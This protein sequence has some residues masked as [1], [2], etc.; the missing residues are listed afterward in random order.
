M[1]ESLPL[2]AVMFGFA[3][4]REGVYDY[5]SARAPADIKFSR[6]SFPAIKM[7]IPPR[8][9]P[10]EVHLDSADLLGL[11]TREAEGI[12][13]GQGLRGS[14]ARQVDFSGGSAV[15]SGT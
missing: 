14:V 5:G 8:D 13:T 7:L 6:Q 4:G 10:L 11:F 1:R 9:A 3:R 15:K 2:K 12:R